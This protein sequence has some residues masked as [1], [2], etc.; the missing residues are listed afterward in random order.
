[1][2]TWV[3]KA[4]KGLTVVFTIFTFVVTVTAAVVTRNKDLEALD[5]KYKVHDVK[6]DKIVDTIAAN[7]KDTSGVSKTVTRIETDVT[8][9]K[10]AI[11]E[12]A[13]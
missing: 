4:W 10:E 3:V 2:I 9:I 8:W 12:L 13:K 1:M 5:A 11:K 7:K 6:L